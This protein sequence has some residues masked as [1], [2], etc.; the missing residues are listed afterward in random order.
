M[1]KIEEKNVTHTIEFQRENLRQWHKKA[2]ILIDEDIE[3]NMIKK[4]IDAFFYHVDSQ[5]LNFNV[6]VVK[7]NKT[8]AFVWDEEKFYLKIIFFGNGYWEYFVKE[9][10][11]KPNMIGEKEHHYK[12]E[13]YKF[14]IKEEDHQIFLLDDD[15]LKFITKSDEYFNDYEPMFKMTSEKLAGKNEVVFGWET[16]RY[17]GTLSGYCY[18][19]KE[20]CF[21]DLIEE[22]DYSSKRCYAIYKL[23]LWDK[24]IARYGQSKIH[25]FFFHF[26]YDFRKKY[27]LKKNFSWDKFNAWKK[28][29]EMIGFFEMY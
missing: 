1:V 8:I 4:D 3:L 18:L 11:I 23:N 16:N 15:V 13:S 27:G 7:E 21:F 17:D 29:K 19:N 6:E 22:Q 5:K 12:G 2:N 10:I 20:L 14:K 24:L 28:S 26:L 9:K 25:I